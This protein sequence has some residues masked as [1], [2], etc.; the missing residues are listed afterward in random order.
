MNGETIYKLNWQYDYW[1][2]IEH[3]FPKG[4]KVDAVVKN[5]TRNYAF[6]STS[7]E[8]TCF[9]D[10]RNVRSHW[11]V[12]DLT[13]VIEPGKAVECTVLDYNFD[14]NNLTVSVNLD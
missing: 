8:V 2:D 1:A 10:K 12:N 7:D 4:C 5:V 3:C 11:T 6:L 14:K 9:L 13:E